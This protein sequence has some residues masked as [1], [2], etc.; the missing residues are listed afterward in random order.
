AGDEG[1]AMYIIEQGKVRICVRAKD[2]HD[3]TLTELHRGDFFGKWRCSM[4]SRARPMR[5]LRRTH[6]W[7][8]FRASIFFPLLAATQMLRWRC[9]QRLPTGYAIQMNFCVTLRRATSMSR[10]QRSLPFPIAQRISSLN[11]AAV[12]NLLLPPCSCS[13]FGYG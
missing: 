6:G 12:G 8:C 11:S 1:N 9:L 2:G 5:G 3:V 4:V 7:L 10:K 13:M